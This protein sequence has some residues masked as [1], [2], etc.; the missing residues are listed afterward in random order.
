MPIF[1]NDT[2]A[3]PLLAVHVW[4]LARRTLMRQVSTPAH[5][6]FFSSAIQ[7]I[8]V[9]QRVYMRIVVYISQIKD[10]RTVFG[11]LMRCHT[12]N[13]IQRRIRFFGIFEHNLTYYR[14]SKL[15]DGDLFLDIGANVGY[16]TLLASRSVGPNGKVISIEA[17]PVTFKSLTTNL[18][19]NSCRNV[20]ACNVEATATACRVTIEPGQR[21]NSGTNRIV[22]G[23]GE[24]S[25]EGLSLRENSRRG[26]QSCAFHQNRY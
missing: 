20:V 22:I 1:T 23:A 11:A 12:R 24:G 4:S 25:V 3:R 15:Q 18:E 19:L 2:D 10:C 5:A 7:I 14:L 26:H 16:F 21:H 6:V 17:D 8:D 9:L 13:F